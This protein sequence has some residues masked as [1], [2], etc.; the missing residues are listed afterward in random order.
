[1]QENK[2]NILL[3]EDED[4]HAEIIRRAFKD[5]NSSAVLR[6]AKNLKEARTAISDNPPQLVV[7]DLLLPDGSG[8]DLLPSAGKNKEYPFLVITS[9]GDETKAVKVIKAGAMDYVIKSEATL[10]DMPRICK[11]CIREWKNIIRRRKAEENLRR[12]HEFSE[13]LINT[14][15][16]IIL[17]LD[18]KG[19][20]IRFNPYME[21][22][23]GYCLKEVKGKDWFTTFLPE[24]DYNRIGALFISAISNNQTGGNVNTIITKDKKKKLIEWQN[25]TIKDESGKVLGLLTIGQDITE[26]KQMEEQIHQSEKM[27]AIGQL[28][29]GIA[30]D[31]N[32]QLTPILGYAD[33]LGNKVIHD[34]GLTRYVNKI[35]IGVKRA[36]EFTSQL[37]SFSRKGK[38]ILTEVNIHSVISEVVSL[39][40]HSIEK[41]I[42]IRQQLNANSSITPGDPDQLQSMFLNISLNARD[43]M[44]DGGKLIFKTSVVE[45]DIE[46]CKKSTFDITAGKYI[47]ICI[48]D[49]GMG[50]DT[51][52]QR[53]I[54]EPFFTTKALGK[55]TG[56]GLAA[57]YGIVINH[58]GFLH[59]R[60]EIGHGTT[61]EIYLPIS[62]EEILKCKEDLSIEQLI[63]GSGFILFVDD[64]EDIR[65]MMVDILEC[66]GYK[67]M[68]YENGMEALK[69]YKKSWMAIDLVILDMR[70]PI[71]NGMEIFDAMKKINP[72][73][74]AFIASGFCLDD[75]A[76]SII[77]KGIKGL[78]QKPFQIV[79]ISKKIK[80]I[81]NHNK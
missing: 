53:H 56:M 69:F 25:K 41:K 26:R 34:P 18:T 28:A 35:Q 19:K 62:V 21:K 79:E 37:L 13:N 59:V 65:H 31:L 36:S 9:H 49:T 20:I 44:P 3:V 46:S 30:H 2:V 16:I 5:Q 23:S 70:M 17:V 55:G 27:R 12:E 4:S 40:K 80:H 14:A 68:V 64:E 24:G 11:R 67:I 52:T 33:L 75:K 8:L 6:I 32:N 78:I 15:Q 29:A 57:V 45:L 22:L 54:F 81:L 61:F 73:V 47:K 42:K 74:V 38:Y 50:M 10:A 77:G 60:S 72:D 39:L 7:L 43:A 48:T 1:M 63:K 51:E 58:K 66:L 71:M 76:Q